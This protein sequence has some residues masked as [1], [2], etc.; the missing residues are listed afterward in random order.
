MDIQGGVGRS[1]LFLEVDGIR[2]ASHLSGSR[3]GPLNEFC[4]G[5][6]KEAAERFPITFTRFDLTSFIVELTLIDFD[7]MRV[8]DTYIDN[9][10]FIYITLQTVDRC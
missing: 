3:K 2:E 4:T 7:L 10:T 6:S 9:C 5:P 1:V 8:G